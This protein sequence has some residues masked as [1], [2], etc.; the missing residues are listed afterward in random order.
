MLHDTA[1]RDH[2]SAREAVKRLRENVDVW[3]KRSGRDGFTIAGSQS[4]VHT[5]FAT[6]AADEK[7]N[8]ERFRLQI[9]ACAP[10][11]NVAAG[12]FVIPFQI[13]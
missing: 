4:S 6:N 10:A 2:D 3:P 7:E 12:F 13:R 8:K 9:F 1:N 5:K 11:T